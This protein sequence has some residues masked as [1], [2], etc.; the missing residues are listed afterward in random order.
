MK[1]E[2]DMPIL[3]QD[4]TEPPMNGRCNGKAS[5]GAAPANGKAKNGRTYEPPLRILGD[6]DDVLRAAV[7]EDAEDEE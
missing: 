4:E 5:N 1:E 6:L 3:G 2:S 7:K